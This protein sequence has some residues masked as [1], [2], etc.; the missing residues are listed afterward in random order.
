[1]GRPRQEVV[2]I[3]VGGNGHILEVFPENPILDNVD[4][5]L[6][7]PNIIEEIEK[8]KPILY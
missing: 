8:S 1:L 6:I 2:S 5:L 4:F 3:V 7:G